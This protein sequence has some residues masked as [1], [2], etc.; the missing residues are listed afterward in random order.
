MNPFTYEEFQSD[1]LEAT[2][3][4]V[5]NTDYLVEDISDSS[6]RLANNKKRI[7]FALEASTL[8]H[9]IENLDGSD[10]IAIYELFEKESIEDEYPKIEVPCFISIEESLS[11]HKES[12]K[13]KVKKMLEQLTHKLY[14][15]I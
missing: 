11:F 7:I 2:K 14:K 10:S 6:I 15:Y 9:I 5:I 4:F 13:N 12:N 8:S 1:M 3:D